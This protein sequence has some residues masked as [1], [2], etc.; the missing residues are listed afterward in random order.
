MLDVEYNKSI[1]QE[2]Q[3]MNDPKNMSRAGFFT[4]IELLVVIAIIAILASMLLPALGRA[5]E[6]ARGSLCESNLKQCGAA[7]M[8]YAHDNNDVIVTKS[9]NPDYGTRRWIEYLSGKPVG[10]DYITN[11]SIAV[12]PSEEP[13]KFGDNY[14]AARSST[15][16]ALGRVADNPDPGIF[17]PPDYAPASN[18]FVAL[19]RLRRSSQSLLLT[20]SYDGTKQTYIIFFHW[21]GAGIGH[22]HLRLQNMAN[23]LFAD[24]HVSKKDT[25]EL[26]QLGASYYYNQNKTLINY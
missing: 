4:L 7:F 12:C 13:F 2:K 8:L 16:G 15:Y 3:Q 21:T 18:R 9:Y 5:R 17:S 20:D 19:N 6:S 25:L 10:T 24:G 11:Y 14:A 22:V 26:K 1:I 23:A